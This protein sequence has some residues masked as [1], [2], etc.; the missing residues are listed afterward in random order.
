MDYPRRKNVEPGSDV[1]ISFTQNW[2]FFGL[3]NEIFGRQLAG[4]WWQRLTGVSKSMLFRDFVKQNGDGSLILTTSKLAEYTRHWLSKTQRASKASRTKQFLHLR[5]CLIEANT[6]ALLA[7]GRPHY[8]WRVLLSIFVIMDFL[9]LLIIYADKEGVVVFPAVNLVPT[10][11]FVSK[12]LLGRGWCPNEAN[13]LCA[14]FGPS[15]IYYASA[16]DNSGRNK[17]H[18]DCNGDQCRAEI[19]PKTNYTTQH[20]KDCGGCQFL[21][22]GQNILC[23]I[24]E[25]GSVP[26]VTLETAAGVPIRVNVTEWKSGMAYVAISHVWSD[27]LGNVDANALPACQVIYIQ[28]TVNKALNNG[29]VL[30]PFWID[31]LCCPRFPKAARNLAISRM[32]ETY[33]RALAVLVLDAYLQAQLSRDLSPLELVMHVACAPWQRRL[34]TF[35][36][37]ALARHLLI[38]FEDTSLDLDLTFWRD[39]WAEESWENPVTDTLA[40]MVFEIRGLKGLSEDKPH[41]TLEEVSNAL[42]FRYTSEAGDEAVC[43]ATIL[44]FSALEILSIAKEDQVGRMKMFW[45]SMSAIPVSLISTTGAKLKEPGCRWAPATFLGGQG[46]R[47]PLGDRNNARY[48]QFRELGLEFA[49]SGFILNVPRLRH[50]P[51]GDGDFLFKDE[52]NNWYSVIMMRPVKPRDSWWSL[53]GSSEI[54]LIMLSPI[55]APNSFAHVDVNFETTNGVLASVSQSTIDQ[56]TTTVELI[57]RVV[58]TLQSTRALRDLRLVEQRCA[59]NLSPE[60]LAT[61]IRSWGYSALE[62]EDRLA[63]FATF[64]MLYYSITARTVTNHIWCL[65]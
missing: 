30:V 32:R 39:V 27:G 10:D 6:R 38:Q 11:G 46:A 18:S 47:I 34:W 19:L 21:S 8:D 16:L 48:A 54:A 7:E 60:E 28:D 55:S 36:E 44:G 26:L 12:L 57:G 49:C 4:N 14:K 3:L 9:R 63:R 58:V 25:E 64:A 65:T 1:D 43:L 62:D 42:A 17:S 15:A 33:E 24:L 2:L 40:R 22:V 37:G 45:K 5:E 31:T 41:R 29:E 50:K 59:G 56:E 51:N 35:Q 61:L 53:D 23:R 20:R 52:M 13:R